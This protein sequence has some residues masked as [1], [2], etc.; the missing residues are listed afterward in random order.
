MRVLLLLLLFTFV[1]TIG[2]QPELPDDTYLCDGD[3]RC[4]PGMT[5]MDGRCRTGALDGGPDTSLPDDAGADA[6]DAPEPIDAGPCEVDDECPMSACR[7]SSCVD[8]A[9]ESTPAD[10]G[11]TDPLCEPGESCCGGGCVDLQSDPFHCGLCGRVCPTGTCEEG[12]CVGFGGLFLQRQ[13]GADMCADNPLTGEQTCPRATLLR[14]P[15]V[16]TSCTV[17][18]EAELFVCGTPSNGFLG[19]FAEVMDEGRS[20]TDD[21]LIPNEATGTCRCPRPAATVLLELRAA[22]GVAEAG[23]HRVGLC[24]DGGPTPRFGGVYQMR[25]ETCLSGN[26][27]ADGNCVCPEDY[28]PSATEASGTRIF[29]CHR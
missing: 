12:A 10:D 29:T 15:R 6:P 8:G 1:F 16:A 14:L 26:P 23:T 11:V 18:R 7:I 5:C 25:G 4:P 3:G 9:C 17:S 13:V 28:L 21:C 24:F 20:C 27:F 19:G 2:C 22:C